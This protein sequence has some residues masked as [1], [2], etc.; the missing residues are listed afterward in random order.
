MIVEP[1]ND[2]REWE[3]FI[4][5]SPDGTFFHT[6]KWRD[7]LEMS[8]HYESSY[9]CIRD[10]SGQLVGVCP[11]FITKKLW[12]LKVLDSLPDSDLGGPLF[13]EEF[14]ENCADAL[15]QYL[16]GLSAYKGITY[17]K[18]RLSDRELCEYLKTE[19]SRVDTSG[20]TTILDL[21]EKPKEFIWNELL[22][23]K[24]GERK[25]IRRF[26]KDGFQSREVRNLEDLNAF[27][28]IYCEHKN[29]L[30]VQSYSYEYFKNIWDLLYPD[31]FEIIL[32]EKEDECIGATAFFT[33][34]EKSTVYRC[35]VGYNKEM[36]SSRYKYTYYDR[37]KNIEWA[38]KR[39]FRYVNDGPTSSDPNSKNY[40]LKSSFGFEFNQ[41]YYIYIPHKEKLF[42]IR[43]NLIKIGRKT[44]K[45]LPKSV[46]SEMGRRLY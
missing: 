27:Y 7:V 32:I 34:K 10:S 2:E 8:F 9:L 18:M 21:S 3:D 6:L 39:G 1:L 11:L 16:N 38:Q 40:S 14:K 23:Q 12:P 46:Y 45:V 20:G 44:K 37:W 30:G 15:N 43:E 25:L 24:G 29:H 28:N 17:T 31:N 41:D 36:L 42:F 33:Y 19:T 5:A 26:D 4:A 13:N 35:Y 22:T